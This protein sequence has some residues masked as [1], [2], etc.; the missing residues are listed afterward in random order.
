MGT[1]SLFTHLYGLPQIK[2]LFYDIALAVKWNNG[3]EKSIVA[4][5]NWSGDSLGKMD[6]LAGNDLGFAGVVCEAPTAQA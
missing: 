2:S 1:I 4:L 3:L 5:L 6:E